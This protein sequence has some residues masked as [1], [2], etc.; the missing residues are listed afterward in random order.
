[1]VKPHRRSFQ[2]AVEAQLKAFRIVFSLRE[3]SPTREEY[4]RGAIQIWVDIWPH[5]DFSPL[6]PEGA[7]MHHWPQY[8]I[9]VVE[10]MLPLTPQ[11]KPRD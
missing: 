7:R 4:V 11:T 8:A 1:M 5:V 6:F 9:E 10:G 3:G 2:P